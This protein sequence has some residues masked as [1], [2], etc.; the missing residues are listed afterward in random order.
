MKYHFMGLV[1][2]SGN[3]SFSRAKSSAEAGGGAAGA[4][5]AASSAG[6][7]PQNSSGRQPSSAPATPASRAAHSPNT[8]LQDLGQQHPQRRRDP[9][10]AL[11]RD[12]LADLLA[13]RGAGRAMPEQRRHLGQRQPPLG[14]A[15][16]QGEE[17]A[18]L[19][20]GGDQGREARPQQQRAV[21]ERQARL[22][23]GGIGR[24]AHAATTSPELSSARA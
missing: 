23:A 1:H 20:F 18:E 21:A 16:D 3:I 14:G 2:P 15:L 8:A 19:G 11:R 17:R 9:G 4:R 12:R 10:Q 7:A 6:V 22:A 13:G 5:I 24:P